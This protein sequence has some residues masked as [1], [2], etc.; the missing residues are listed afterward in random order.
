MEK[1]IIKFCL[2]QLISWIKT[3]SNHI[4]KKV[5]KV[6]NIHDGVVSYLSGMLKCEAKVALGSITTNQAS[7]G[8]RIPAELFQILKDD[9]VK[10]LHSIFFALY[11]SL[12]T[13]NPSDNQRYRAFQ[14]ISLCK[15]K[16]YQC[17]FLSLASLGYDYCPWTWMYWLCLFP[18]SICVNSK[19]NAIYIIQI[20]VSHLKKCQDILFHMTHM[21]GSTN[22]VTMGHLWTVRVLIIFFFP[23][24][25]LKDQRKT[26]NNYRNIIFKNSVLKTQNSPA[27]E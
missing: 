12:N 18:P 19:I 24:Q 25:Y 16:H 11:T 10:V 6:A 21:I 14:Q 15:F 7:G 3:Q 1:K 22:L 27:I 26:Y 4:L 9:S 23:A 13:S 2:K 8:D 5:F 20:N 17:T